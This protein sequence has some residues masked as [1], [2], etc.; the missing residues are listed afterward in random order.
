MVRPKKNGLMCKQDISQ[1]IGSVG[2]AGKEMGVITGSSQRTL[3]F[4]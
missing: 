2:D 4:L 1:H 3:T